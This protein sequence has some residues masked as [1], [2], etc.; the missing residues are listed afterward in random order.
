MQGV[1]ERERQEVKD[2]QT[3][4]VVERLVR[5]NNM[6]VQDATKLWCE[7]KTKKRLHDSGEDDYL[8]TS[9]MHCY[10]ELMREV[11]IGKCVSCL[12]N[13]SCECK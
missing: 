10:F 13:Q 5:D 11:E 3:S 6:S 9:P 2:L 1:D 4:I 7:S 8:F 12:H